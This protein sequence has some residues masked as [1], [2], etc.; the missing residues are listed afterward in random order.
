MFNDDK[1][2]IRIDMSEFMERHATSRLIGSPPGYVGH[3]DGGQLTEIVRH[4]PY[5]LI[6]FD[7]I[8]KA[9]PEVF[10]LLLQVLD[11]GRLTD[12]KGKIVNFKNCIIIMTSNVGS[13]YLRA[14]SSIGFQVQSASGQLSQEETFKVKTLEALREHFRPEFLNRIDDVVV[15]NP[16]KP[17]DLEQIVDIQLSLIHERLNERR[18]KLSIDAPAKKYLVTHGFDPDFGARPLKRL[19]Q[20]VILDALAD[21]IIRGEVKDGDKI[22]VNCKADSLVL[23]V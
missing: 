23:S 11:N 12:S 8:E 20:K 21:K 3:E 7:E 18:I 15:F 6:L 5:S 1:A 2:L 10:N 19:I 14:M 9:H 16:L 17:K 4:R 22:K 13:Q